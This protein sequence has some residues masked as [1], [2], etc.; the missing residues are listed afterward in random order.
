MGR[1]AQPAQT[2]GNATLAYVETRT[3]G[4]RSRPNPT[5]PVTCTVHRNT[6]TG[7]PAKEGVGLVSPALGNCGLYRIGDTPNPDM[8]E[9]YQRKGGHVHG[10]VPGNFSSSFFLFICI[11]FLLRFA[12]R[13]WLVA[14]V[15][16]DS[17]LKESDNTGYWLRMSI[18]ASATAS[19]PKSDMQKAYPCC[20]CHHVQSA[21]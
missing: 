20:C 8:I 15:G 7:C 2:R 4:H 14:G 11:S 10:G 12:W 18:C 17:C 9:A 13:Y 6:T 5:G 21:R 16:G 1:S 19:R 3:K